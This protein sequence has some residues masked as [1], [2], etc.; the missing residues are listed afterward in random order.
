MKVLI[1]GL[2]GLLGS[3]IAQILKN[4][5]FKIK[6]II[7]KTSNLTSLNGVD[8]ESHYCDINN[9]QGVKSAMEECEIVI[10]TA[11]DTNHFTTS[12]KEAF[13]INYRGVK[14][15]L[16]AAKYHKV[17]KVIYVGTVNLF[18]NG[19]FSRPGNESSPFAYFRNN[20]SYIQSKYQAHL[21][22]QEEIKKGLPALTVHPS[23]MLGAYD[24]KPSSGQII[25]YALKNKIVPVPPGGKNF[26]H[27]KDVARAI[28]N[29]I[30]K[31]KIGESYILGHEN[32]SY[33][34]FF[35]L[36]KEVSGKSF[37]ELNIPTPIVLTIGKL[38]E[39]WQNLTQ[40]HS[41][42][43][44]SNSE[45]LCDMHYYS[46]EKACR[47]LAFPQTP[48]REAI[49]DALEWFIRHNYL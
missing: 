46:S 13:D 1:T 34:Q 4:E 42:L 28:V 14:N 9:E 29:A 19:R 18:G 26:V 36:V 7:R 11:A 27:V 44:V 16:E 6:G 3:N 38:G 24:C 41:G 49:K 39:A 17:K 35:T 47:E 45:L 8:F 12:Y 15:V 21:L 33:K 25:L 10:H 30:E 43:T 23:F 32:L 22:I 40:T 48:I 31:G 5:N 20:S 37:I 2:S